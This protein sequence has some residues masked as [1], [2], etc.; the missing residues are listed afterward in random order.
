MA[1]T[2]DEPEDFEAVWE[3]Q[4]AP[5]VSACLEPSA[6][7]NDVVESTSLAALHDVLYRLCAAPPGA[8]LAAQPQRVYALL[9]AHLYVHARAVA[10]ILNGLLDGSKCVL[11]PRPMHLVS[12]VDVARHKRCL[13]KQI[14]VEDPDD[15]GAR[16]SSSRMDGSRL[17]PTYVAFWKAYASGMENIGALF[18]YLDRV[19]ISHRKDFG[20]DALDDADREALGPNLCIY[21]VRAAAAVAWK[22]EVLMPLGKFIADSVLATVDEVRASHSK[23]LPSKKDSGLLG[24][25]A[26]FADNFSRRTDNAPSW[27]DPL[28]NVSVVLQSMCAVSDA[29]VVRTAQIQQFTTGV[30]SSAVSGLPPAS[31]YL[32]PL[33]PPSPERKF[34]KLALYYS[35]FEEPFLSTV[36]RF[37]TAEAEAMLA[38]MA[39]SDYVR[40]VESILQSEMERSSKY[41][42]LASME[43]LRTVLERVLIADRAT[44]LRTE[45][46]RQ[47]RDSSK[48]HLARL[49]SLFS[50]VPDALRPFNAL[51]RS[52]VEASGLLAL[53]PWT[54]QTPFVYPPHELAP[55]ASESSHAVSESLKAQSLVCFVCGR[56]SEGVGG[57]SV[58]AEGPR[59]SVRKTRAAGFVST[60]WAVYER[61]SSIVEESFGGDRDFANA[62]EQGC[63]RFLNSV[64]T[65]PELLAQFCHE[66]LEEPLSLGTG[67]QVR[68]T[69]SAD[70]LTTCRL[71]EQDA[72]EWMTRVTRIFRF[73]NDRDLFQSVYALKLARRL[74]YR[75]SI[76]QNV[77]SA[78]I[79]LLRDT[80]GIDY[81]SRLQ[82]MFADVQVSAHQ[83]LAFS[84]ARQNGLILLDDPAE[85]DLE[86][87]VLVLCSSAWP[88]L[89]QSL[90]DSPGKTEAGLH[91]G[92]SDGDQVSAKLS[93]SA[94][95]VGD[96]AR[97]ESSHASASSRELDSDIPGD[98]KQSQEFGPS[99]SAV[100]LAA[101]AAMPTRISR[102]SACFGEYYI[103]A[104]GHE[105]RKLRWMHHLCRVEISTCLT[106]SDSSVQSGTISF[107]L[108]AS[109]PQAA[110]LLQFNDHASMSLHSLSTALGMGMSELVPIVGVLV[111]ARILVL[112]GGVRSAI[113]LSDLPKSLQSVHA[114][115]MSRGDIAEVNTDVDGFKLMKDKLI[116]LALIS[117]QGDDATQVRRV[118]RNLEIDR[119][120]QIKACIVRIM[121]RQKRVEQNEL[122]Q[123]VQDQTSK[124]F[125]PREGDVIAGIAALVEHEY[126]AFSNG[127]YVY[128][129]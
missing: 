8:A 20:E 129:A 26:I 34:S 28:D 122:V 3:R 88:Y 105:G 103:A 75:T 30:M 15:E 21:D 106:A 40:Q 58:A 111:Q 7:S 95:R 73:L 51:L 42:A 64:C 113:E 115:S 6:S 74:V 31:M 49:Y 47:L 2:T 43:P 25:A 19:W 53:R 72:L 78:M 127:S 67:L 93:T 11:A 57:P 120:Q 14:Q 123:A 62:L 104:Q 46:D 79:L 125:L 55:S 112:R 69:G 52:H 92:D 86:F 5:V 97:T 98:Q 89:S 44:I 85:S 61:Y 18:S 32:D 59:C 126:I 77:E 56:Y 48:D 68:D 33:R 22:E 117:Y 39:V 80:C 13:L 29:G 108:D 119:R 35:L 91:E 17:T 10:L 9:R 82:R 36:A 102:L 109:L 54:L 114:G 118:K 65:A 94:A 41:V 71:T 84:G 124:W 83:S 90:V 24:L 66:I 37:Y 96:A 76:S 81:T 87:D 27:K 1:S 60:A 110:V 16:L 70:N 63:E 50:R 99:S 23:R 121:K 101:L 100:V 107:A 45:A 116:R 128:V 4:L 12:D 38:Q